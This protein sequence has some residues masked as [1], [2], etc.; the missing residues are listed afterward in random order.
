M[1]PLFKLKFILDISRRLLD[2]F[3]PSINVL[4]FTALIKPTHNLC[5]N[6]LH[7]CVK[8]SYVFRFSFKSAHIC[9]IK[10][11]MLT[12]SKYVQWSSS[13]SMSTHG[14]YDAADVWIS[15]CFYCKTSRTLASHKII[16]S[17]IRNFYFLI[18]Y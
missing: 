5:K 14:G 11:Y 8:V 6:T 7:P 4:I 15:L 9:S 17:R 1:Q 12:T 16:I 10:F 2:I 18:E 3:I 13:L